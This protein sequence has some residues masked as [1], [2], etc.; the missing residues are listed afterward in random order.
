VAKA[1]GFSLEG[2]HDEY[3]ITVSDAVRPAIL[4]DCKTILH[5]GGI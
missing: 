4:R 1:T 3:A 2:V 5:A